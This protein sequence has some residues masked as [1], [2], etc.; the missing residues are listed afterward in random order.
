[1]LRSPRCELLPLKGELRF[2]SCGRR[3]FI[4]SPV[5]TQ[6]HAPAAW[7][8]GGGPVGFVG[9]IVPHS[10]HAG[11]H[12]YGSRGPGSVFALPATERRPA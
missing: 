9:R 8:T 3:V 5:V 11:L 1:M 2:W 7:R 6:S 4:L 10:G 12:P